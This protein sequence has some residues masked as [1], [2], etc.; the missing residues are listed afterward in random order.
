MSSLPLAD[1]GPIWVWYASFA[2]GIVVLVAISVAAAAA[3][4]VIFGPRQRDSLIIPAMATFGV[5]IIA[6]FAS[7]PSGIPALLALAAT[8]GIGVSAIQR[9]VGDRVNQESVHWPTFVLVGGIAAGACVGG[10]FGFMARYGRDPWLVV[11]GGMIGAIIGAVVSL[12]G[13]VLPAMSRQ[14]AAI[15]INPATPPSDDE[16]PAR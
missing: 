1:M 11:A 12:R 3:G 15:E 6:L 13:S 4:V 9:F 2:I 5:V 10:F 16:D 8:V 14:A 7:P